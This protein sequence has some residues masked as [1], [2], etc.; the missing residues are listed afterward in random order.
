MAEHVTIRC[1]S[2]KQMV[3]HVCNEDFSENFKRLMTFVL[4]GGP[5]PGLVA[6]MK[7]EPGMYEEGDEKAPFFSEAFLYSLVGKMNARTILALIGN[8]ARAAGIDPYDYRRSEPTDK[9]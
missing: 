5:S 9:S 3:R 8:L 6:A 1:E 4:E 2:C 7:E